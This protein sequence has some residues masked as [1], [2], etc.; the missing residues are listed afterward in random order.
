M[1]WWNQLKSKPFFIKLLN[2][3][4]WPTPAFYTPVFPYYVYCAIRA[5]HAAYFSAV[6]P[7][8]KTGGIGDELKYDTIMMI[9]E[10]YRPK[11]IKVTHDQDFETTLKK[12]KQ[13]GISF[14][15]IAKPDI[16]FRGI[17]VKK[18][19]D[20]QSLKNHL[21]RLPID[22]VIQEFLQM[23][24]EFGVLFYRLPDE[25][26][27][28]ISS[29]T[30]KE[31]LSITG[32]GRSTVRE[33]AMKKERAKLQIDR[34][35]MED[36]ELLEKIPEKGAYI[37]L[38][39]IGNHNKGTRFINGNHLINDAIIKT[40]N[41]INKEMQGFYYGRFDLKCNSLD[42]LHTGENI[43]ILELNGVFAEPTHMYDPVA[44]TYFQC[45]KTIMKHWEI[46]YRISKENHKRGEPYMAVKA[47]LREMFSLYR[48]KQ[49]L[50][51]VQEKG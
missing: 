40:F 46:I 33:L 44:G 20:E 27:G 41:R 30:T 15:L 22:F 32:D 14:P 7:A 34:L 49:G 42:D 4:Y 12:I 16:G 24:A 45:L 2:W 28:N 26:K 1:N 37:S 6:N 25:E 31:F 47:M 43:K 5:K 13:A 21:K 3:E 48:Y 8:L 35:S 11:S 10:K 9:P 51:K 38:G 18:I 36:P 19:K 17:L 23:D 39:E 50:I 29:I